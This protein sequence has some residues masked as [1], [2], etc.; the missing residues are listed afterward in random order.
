MPRHTRPVRTP[1]RWR[2]PQWF[3][4]GCDRV[5]M[6]W[7]T[8][9]CHVKKCKRYKALM[10][11]RRAPLAQPADPAGHGDD[12]PLGGGDDVDDGVSAYLAESG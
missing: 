4:R 12:G 5:Y 6:T 1:Q 8:H 10:R 2:T 7:K 3:C 9:Q 11:L